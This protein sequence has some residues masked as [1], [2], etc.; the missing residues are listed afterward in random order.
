MRRLRAPLLLTIAALALRMFIAIGLATDEP[1]DGRL[2]ARLAHN[3]LSAHVYSIDERV[4]FTPTYIRVPGYPLFIA[5]VYAAFGDGNNTMVRSVQAALDTATCW[6]VA[7]LAAAWTPASWSD[8]GRRR[9]WLAAL[10]LAAVCPF[11]M[12]YTA[13]LLTE[14]VSLLLGTATVLVSTWALASSSTRRRLALWAAAGALAGL[15]ALVRPENGLYL[16]VAGTMILL[17]A[18]LRA[19]RS[20]ESGRMRAVVVAAVPAWLALGLGFAAALAPWTVRNAMVFG[21]FEPLNPQSVAMPDEF[22]AVGYETWVRT[23]IDHPRYIWPVLFSIDRSPIETRQM[24]DSAF[25]SPEE[26]ARVEGL[27]AEYNRPAPDADPDET[28][29]YPPG[30]MT[31]AIDAGFAALAR[32][33]IARRPFTYYVA[34][35]VRR[36]LA[37]WF[38]PHA[39]FYPF[40]GFLVPLRDLDRDQEQQVWLPLFLG[41]LLAWTAGGWAG[42]WRLWHEP[43]R[44]PWVVFVALLI[45]PRLALLA[46]LPNP[47]PRYTVE[48][49]PLVSA[50]AACWIGGVRS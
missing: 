47:E 44:R 22:V 11:T 23:W 1:D 39:D 36:A 33:R 31:P 38:N 50:L 43:D 49:F 37:L 12:I 4:P 24:P 14:T 27:L 48:F 20:A 29:Q 15:S 6:L 2:Y 10:A 40:S 46:W 30:G 16:A 25:D 9:T 13:A 19:R 42:A 18:V 3:L 28:G 7:L 5:G 21:R 34:L 8:A 26:R 35:P 32:E 41:V 45:V 17:V